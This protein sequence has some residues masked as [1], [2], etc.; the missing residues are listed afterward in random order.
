MS[1]KTE[2]YNQFLVR[3]TPQSTACFRKLEINGKIFA[4]FDQKIVTDE[5]FV[6]DFS[7]RNVIIM[8]PIT[9]SKIVKI[10]GY[11]ILLL[12]PVYSETQKA[13]LIAKEKMVIYTSSEENLPNLLYSEKMIAPVSSSKLNALLKQFNE[14]IQKPDGNQ[15]FDALIETYKVLLPALPPPKN[16]ADA[17]YFFD[18][19][20]ELI[21]SNNMEN[22]KKTTKTYQ[23]KAKPVEIIKDNE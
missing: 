9:S 1:S 8:A 4:L 12:A 16:S 20:F 22:I 3:F 2:L 5:S 10:M 13:E 18:I 19:P 15:M 7:D 17:Y 11:N 21:E 14:G 6:V 23:C